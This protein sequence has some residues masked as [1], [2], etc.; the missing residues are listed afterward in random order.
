MVD[1]ESLIVT[2]QEMNNEMD[3]TLQRYIL[4]LLS[5]SFTIIVYYYCVS[6]VFNL[7]YHGQARTR[8]L[9]NTRKASLPLDRV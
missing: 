1:P 4:L 3:N 6:K 7:K 2:L 8:D 9:T 5:I